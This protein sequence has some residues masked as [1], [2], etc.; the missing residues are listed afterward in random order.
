MTCLTK[1]CMTFAL[2]L[3]F[4]GCSQQPNST[5]GERAANDAVKP[6]AAT[7]NDLNTATANDLAQTIQGPGVVVDSVTYTGDP[8]AS[9]TF[10]FTDQDDVVGFKY[11]QMKTEA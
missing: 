2:A 5:P 11:P 4:A 3:L 7:L 6:L 10:D 9:G 1:W 8:T